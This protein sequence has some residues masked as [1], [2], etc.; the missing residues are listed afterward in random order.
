MS[1][2]GSYHFH[3][4]NMK[5]YWTFYEPAINMTRRLYQLYPNIMAVRSVYSIC[6]DLFN[7]ASTGSVTGLFLIKWFFYLGK[8]P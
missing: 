1:N 3:T 5:V 6:L 8:S 2:R 4:R 7:V